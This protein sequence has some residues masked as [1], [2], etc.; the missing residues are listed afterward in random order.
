MSRGA[1][2]VIPIVALSGSTLKPPALPGI[3]TLASQ[4]GCTK[5]DLSAPWS[6]LV[7][8]CL[9]LASAVLYTLWAGKDVS[10]D[11]VNY[12]LYA[13]F[14]AL[15]DRFDKDFFAASIQSYLNPYAHVP[16]YVLVKA[17]I[18]PAVIGAI[19]AGIH[20]A[21]L[22]IVLGILRTLFPAQD[23]VA[24]TMVAFGVAAAAIAPIFLTSI[25]TTFNDATVSILV[26]TA[27]WTLAADREIDW[28]RLSAAGIAMGAAVALKLTSAP[29]VVGYC[30]AIALY[31]AGIVEMIR[32]QVVVIGGTI[33]GFAV[34]G[35]AWAFELASRFGNP[36]FPFFNGVFASEHYLAEDFKHYRF[37]PETFLEGLLF[38]LRIAL[39]D[40]NVYTEVS[41][42][43]IRIAVIIVLAGLILLRMFFLRLAKSPQAVAVVQP[44]KLR[45]VAANGVAF[46]LLIALSG[47]GRYMMPSFL[48]AGPILAIAISCL[49]RNARWIYYSTAAILVAQLAMFVIGG[50][51][52]WS[53]ASWGDSWFNVEVPPELSSQPAL[54]LSIGIQPAAF[55]AP[56]SHPDAGFINVFGQ[57]PLSPIG[58]GGSAVRRLLER[59]DDHVRVLLPIPY[60]GQDR[61]PVLPDEER[62]N[63]QLMPFE[64]S[65]K[66]G[67]CSFVYLHDLEG[68]RVFR[69]EGSHSLVLADDV[70]FGGFAVCE[71]RRVKMNP[72]YADELAD[73]DKLF[74]LI[75]ER[76]PR[77]FQ[78]KNSVSAKVGGTWV[79]TYT[80][81]D[82]RLYITPVKVFFEGYMIP[83]SELARRVD[84]AEGKWIKCPP[85]SRESYRPTRGA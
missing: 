59:Y 39:P 82:M 67:S 42:P 30:A 33:A 40:R 7:A 25:G 57:Y 29:Y 21:N 75:E 24:K 76:C 45:F 15:N 16:F 81:T 71:T 44:G 62:V 19:L 84:L 49:S 79:R 6:T 35:G 28:K 17:G 4:T 36:F 3:P 48:M 58:P 61:Q 14:S 46:V 83:P 72:K 23:S 34:A 66:P 78:P 80:N 85:L 47:N 54:Y 53:A 5:Q 65:L 68:R 43:D 13:G 64:R 1:A 63:S 60:F 70:P 10:W 27:Y 41:A 74:A 69:D 26:L 51:R 56:F 20:A 18:K 8:G 55:L 50:D 9:I 52:R 22:L 31:R 12:H 32:R 73:I 38:P 11:Q 77:L 37:L 2:L